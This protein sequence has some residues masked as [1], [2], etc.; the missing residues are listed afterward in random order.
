[1]KKTAFVLAMAG[2]AAVASAD[3]TDLRITELFVGQPANNGTT[4][5]LELTNYGTTSVSTGGL[6][7]DDD[8]FDSTKNDALDAL[9][10]APGES[11]VF[12]VSWE[13]DFTVASDAIDQFVAFW[14]TGIKVGVVTGGSGLGG[15]GDAAAVFANNTDLVPI[16]SASYTDL[17]GLRGTIDYAA[18]SSSVAFRTNSN[19]AESMLS[20][21]W[22]FESIGT[23]DDPARTL[24]GS[25][26]AVPAPAAAGLL[27]LAGLGAAR[28]R[29]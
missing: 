4:D 25:P 27:G 28:R 8:S 12:L 10:L 23:A 5:W 14:G 29:R 3:V 7:Y 13:D 9:T 16:T 17:G 19:G 6:F 26:G 22:V 1:M 21:P 18:V 15:G 24:Y 2:V 20:M 11:A